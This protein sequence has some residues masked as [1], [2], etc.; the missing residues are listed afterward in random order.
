[1]NLS[2]ARQ[3]LAITSGSLARPTGS[4]RNPVMHRRGALLTLTDQHGTVGR[5]E[6]SPLPGHSTESLEDT[7]GV[8]SE[9][10]SV[11]FAVCDSGDPVESIDTALKPW[12]K[13][14][15]RVPSARFALETALLEI[16]STRRGCSVA[17]LLC[18]STKSQPLP[19]VTLNAAPVSALDPELVARSLSAIEWGVAAIKVKLGA[20]ETSGFAQELRA[21]ETLRAHIGSAE[22]RVDPNASWTVSLTHSRARDLAKLGVSFI[23]QPVATELLSQLGPLEVPWAADEAMADP[24]FVRALFDGHED[25]LGCSSVVLKPALVGG[26]ISARRLALGAAQRNLGVVVTHLF[27]GPIALAA[28]C[29]LALSLQTKP[30]ACGLDRH[31]GLKVWPECDLLQLRERARVV[32]SHKPGLG[33]SAFGL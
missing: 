20:P 10:L 12:A 24:V 11:P 33:V 21:L 13:V 5:G 8:L 29:E 16:I 4:V 28:C 25:L 3:S 32:P 14:L 27:D 31:G 23:E 1:M 9:C 17:S 6:A 26:V 18:A 2:I 30:L 19:F 22:L 7:L 15:S